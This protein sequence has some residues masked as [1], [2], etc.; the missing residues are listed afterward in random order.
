MT[1]ASTVY[2]IMS[3]EIK[4]CRGYSN[5]LQILYLLKV[6]YLCYILGDNL[7]HKF[8]RQPVS[9]SIIFRICMSMI[10]YYLAYDYPHNDIFLYIF[11]I[12]LYDTES[13]YI[14]I[15]LFVCYISILGVIQIDNYLLYLSNQFLILVQSFTIYDHIINVYNN[16]IYHMNIRDDVS[17]RELLISFADCSLITILFM[18]VLYFQ[19]KFFMCGL[20]LNVEDKYYLM[21]Y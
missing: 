1:N 16:L 17:F 8:Y 12:L 4:N 21:N 9:F 15:N 13:V 14:T 10:T 11:Y 18:Y 20:T 7:L 19:H 5:I 6:I 3:P 2:H